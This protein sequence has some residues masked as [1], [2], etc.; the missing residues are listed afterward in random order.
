MKPE[1]TLGDVIKEAGA[2]AEIESKYQEPL[3]YGTTD[4]KAVGTYIEQKFRRYLLEKYGFEPG[5]SAKGIDF[6]DINLEIKTTSIKQPQ[7]SCPFRTAR[8]KVFGLGYSIILFVYDKTD[9]PKTKTANLNFLHTIY[10]HEDKT[11]D[12]QTTKGLRDILDN[13]GNKDDIVAYLFDRNLPID[14]IGAGELAEE[15]LKKKPE[16]GFLTISNALQWRL[17]YARI[18][19]SAGSEEGI[20]ELRRGAE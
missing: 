12:Y 19:Q 2:F 11:G 5:N 3:I 10:V 17:Q 14:E 8:Q 20:V 6:P 13:N 4:G 1:L 7:S 16:Q 18:I 9:D 15:I